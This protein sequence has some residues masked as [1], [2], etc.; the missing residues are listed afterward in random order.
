MAGQLGLREVQPDQSALLHWRNITIDT[1][2]YCTRSYRSCAKGVAVWGG[3]AYQ[4]SV[5]VAPLSGS[6]L[7]IMTFIV[8]RWVEGI[9]NTSDFQHKKTLIWEGGP[10]NNCGLKLAVIDL[11]QLPNLA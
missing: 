8:G 11:L 7:E 3:A 10:A 4:E 2:K 5:A 6:H 1:G 9:Q